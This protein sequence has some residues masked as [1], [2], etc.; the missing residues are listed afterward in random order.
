MDSV[1]V[2]IPVFNEADK[3]QGTHYHVNQYLATRGFEYEILFVDDGSTDDTYQKLLGLNKAYKDVSVLHYPTNK[4]KGYAVRQGLLT[5]KYLTKIILDCD[6][7]VNI[8]ELNNVDFE[9]LRMNHIIKGIRNQIVKQPIHRII[10]GKA[11]K[12]LVFLRTGMFFDTQCPFCVLRIRKGFY[13]R[14]RCNGFAYD[15]E[16]LY[17]A[18]ARNFRID[19]LP[20]DYFDDKDSRVTL[21]KTLRMVRE[22]IELRK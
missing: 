14:L 11:W 20:V 7:S 10:A 17:K 4:G 15:V 9:N 1:S 19:L 6:L 12:V 22:L 18:K 13:L 3:V 5:S 2:I 16:L 8:A 21:R